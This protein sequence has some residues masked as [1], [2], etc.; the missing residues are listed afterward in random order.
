M[1]GQLAQQQRRRLH[2]G[3]MTAARCAHDEELHQHVD[4]EDDV[5]AAV[6][7]EES[8]GPSILG[9]RHEAHLDRRDE[10]DEDERS[11]RDHFPIAHDPA[12]AWIE[13]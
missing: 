4:D 13:K 7:D 6:G 3:V 8:V 9:D 12:L 1:G 5:D 2:G 10:C 11:P